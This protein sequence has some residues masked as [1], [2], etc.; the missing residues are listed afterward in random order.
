MFGY[1]PMGGPVGRETMTPRANHLG[2]PYEKAL[3]RWMADVLD[4]RTDPPGRLWLDGNGSLYGDAVLYRET[5]EAVQQMWPRKLLEF[6]CVS[7][8]WQ[9]Q[10]T[11]VE[12][13]IRQVRIW[14]HPYFDTLSLDSEG[15]MF[16][17]LHEMWSW[18]REM[19]DHRGQNRFRTP[20]TEDLKRALEKETLTDAEEFFLFVL[21]TKLENHP[22]FGPFFRN[23]SGLLQVSLMPYDP[24][25]EE[26]NPLDH[27]QVSKELDAWSWTLPWIGHLLCS[28]WVDLEQGKF[29]SI[30]IFRRNL[31]A[32]TLVIETMINASSQLGAPECLIPVM[33]FFRLCYEDLDTEESVTSLEELMDRDMARTRISEQ[34]NEKDRWAS[35]LSLSYR[36]RDVYQRS[37]GTPPILR[38]PM[39]ELTIAI[40]R[41]IDFAPIVEKI[42][43]LRAELEQEIG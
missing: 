21:G 9:K 43:S 22:V 37:W 12:G 16:S 30:D 10:T 27:T 39:D 28:R 11:T 17:I 3:L 24:K 41:E 31:D 40:W 25:G 18:S 23:R 7:G 4:G 14:D 5:V 32:L 15:S 8:G 33:I 36:V 2:I 35:L 19:W 13:K 20:S 6:L 26:E 42:D 1:G 38:T 34:Q 29:Q